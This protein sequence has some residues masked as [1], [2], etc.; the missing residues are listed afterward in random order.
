MP[1]TMNVKECVFYSTDAARA[2]PLM[3]IYETDDLLVFEVDA[4]GIVLEALSI[5]VCDDVVVIEGDKCKT[6]NAEGSRFFC[7]ERCYDHFKRMVKLPIRVNVA[8]G[9]AVY[10]KG[11]I[12]L[13]FEKTRDRV[14]TITIERATIGD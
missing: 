3:D 9:K 6:T 12:K 13:T 14:I 10:F 1:Q 5:R 11:V 2:M 4:P 8:S 7:M